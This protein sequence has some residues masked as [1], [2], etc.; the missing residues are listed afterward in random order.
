[1]NNLIYFDNAATGYPKPA[2]VIK[3]AMS[4]FENCGGNPGRSGH[5]LSENASRMVYKCRESVC[6]LLNFNLPER[7]VFTLNATHALNLAIKGLASRGDHILISNLEHNSVYRPVY[8]LFEAKENEIEFSIFDATSENDNIIVEN[9]EK[10]LKV[11]T[12]MAVITAASNVCG[13]LLPLRKLSDVCKKYGMLFIID[14]SQACGETEIDFSDIKPD[15]LCS[16]GH[17][18]LYG[19]TGTGFAVFSEKVTPKPLLHGGNGIVSELP[20]MGETL[21]ERLEAGTINT[22]GIIGL[23]AGINY[24]MDY[25]IDNIACRC[26]E[27]EKYITE[28]LLECGAVIYSNFRRKTP[29]ILFN[30]PGISP[31]EVASQLGSKR[32]CTRAGI[33]CAPLAHEALG[34]GVHGA[35]RVSLGYNNNICEAQKFINEINNIKK[36]RK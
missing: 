21:P 8:S 18:G 4:A 19:P 24:I 1:M 27:I 22:F 2:G 9:F 20:E 15:V 17:K 28:G 33:H 35:V 34:T 16:A 31:D 11:N 12:K 29:V 6:R 5:I 30:I 25:G 26:S 32:I 10:S 23:G 7:V 13:K 36:E 14:A 3:A